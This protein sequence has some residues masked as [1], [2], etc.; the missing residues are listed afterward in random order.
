MRI[1]TFRHSNFPSVPLGGADFPTTLL[2]CVLQDMAPVL[3]GGYVLCRLCRP[4]F[5]H[6][7]Q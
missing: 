6:P 4:D 3:R 2:E 7:C 1:A 5:G